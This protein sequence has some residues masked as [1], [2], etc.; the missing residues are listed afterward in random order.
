MQQDLRDAL[1]QVSAAAKS[2]QSLSD[3]LDRNPEALVRG[4]PKDKQ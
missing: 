2:V 3:T 1:Q 4:K